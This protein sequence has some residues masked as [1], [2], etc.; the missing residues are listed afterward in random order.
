MAK[1]KTNKS[2]KKAQKKLKLWEIILFILIVAGAVWYFNFGGKAIVDDL[3]NQGQE[4]I[5]STLQDNFGID[6]KEL[7]GEEKTSETAQATTTNTAFQEEGDIY[8]QL[9]NPICLGTKNNGK[10]DDHEVHSYNGFKLCYRENYEN[11]EWVSYTITKE[12]LNSVTKRTDNFR[13]DPAISTGSSTNADYKKSG[14]DKGH[15]APAADMAWSKESM[16]DCF[17]MSNMSPQAPNFNR[18]IWKELEENVR[19]WVEKFETIT[20]ITG[21]ILEKDANEYKSIG[22]NKV[23]VP[24]YY[25][26]A[27]LT[28]DANQNWTAIGY[29]LPNEKCEGDFFDYAVTVDEIEKRTGLDF[30]SVFPDDIETIVESTYNLEYWQ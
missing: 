15:L 9:E 21:P 13:S 28:K 5:G 16:D 29:I 19:D 18:G 22:E 25:Y 11:A 27:L 1:K 8:A 26:K 2:K 4:K 14:Y 6:L 30:F 24:E 17:Y 10:A 12:E 7:T 3:L 23:S 20:I